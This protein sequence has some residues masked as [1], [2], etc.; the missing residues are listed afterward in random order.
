M[1]QCFSLLS[2]FQTS[3]AQ[4]IDLTDVTA[5]KRNQDCKTARANFIKTARKRWRI[6]W[7]PGMRKSKAPT[8]SPKSI[9]NHVPRF[10]SDYEGQVESRVM[11]LK[12]EGQMDVV[13]LSGRRA[14]IARIS[15]RCR[16]DDGCFRHT[17]FLS[18]TRTG[19]STQRN[20][21][22]GTGSVNVKPMGTHC[23]HQTRLTS[24]RKMCLVLGRSTEPLMYRRLYS[25]Y[26]INVYADGRVFLFSP[27][28]PMPC[29]GTWLIDGELFAPNWEDVQVVVGQFDGSQSF[30]GNKWVF[31]DMDRGVDPYRH[32]NIELSPSLI[33]QGENTPGKPE[34]SVIKLDQLYGTW[35]DQSFYYTFYPDQRFYHCQGVNGNWTVFGD[36][37]F[38]CT[39]TRGV[40]I[41]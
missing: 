41:P 13:E 4:G 5:R 6:F 12:M 21:G 35:A 34:S 29:N 25:T 32:E 40:S 36:K 24:T 30:D 3:R 17:P 11:P 7:A 20:L 14:H 19:R 37:L 9:D 1:N 23:A 26:F 8:V 16:P 2:L 10:S 15:V 22:G 39:W 31:V 28:V 38:M 33:Q 18:S 27:T